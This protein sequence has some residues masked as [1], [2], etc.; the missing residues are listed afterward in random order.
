MKT[1]SLKIA[2]FSLLTIAFTASTA[3]AGTGKNCDHKKKAAMKTNTATA[4]TKV[5]SASG[6]SAAMKAHAKKTYTF[7]EASKLCMDKGAADL[8]AC[9]DYK[10]GKTKMTTPRK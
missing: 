7:D 9:I 2:S 8:Q 3:F 4:Q 10:T 5:L 6:E 1:T